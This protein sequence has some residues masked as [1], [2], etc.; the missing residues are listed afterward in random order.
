MIKPFYK[1]V[2]NVLKFNLKN[3]IMKNLKLV[4]VF[5]AVIAFSLSGFTQNQNQQKMNRGGNGNGTGYHNGSGFGIENRIPDLTDTQ[6]EKIKAE[7][8]KNMKGMLPLKNTLNEKQ[9]HLKT[10]STAEKVD[11]NQVNKT[12]DEIGT[13]KTTMMKKRAAHKQIIRNILTE[14]QRVMFDMHSS[15]RNKKHHKGNMGHKGMRANCPR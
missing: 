11:M 7:R 10:I 12:I 15:K 9:A 14:D 5:V 1:T 2:V 3:K 8:T 6:K 4:L 13:I